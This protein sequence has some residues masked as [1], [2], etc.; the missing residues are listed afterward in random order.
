MLR[1][2]DFPW[3]SLA[4][5]KERANAFSD[6]SLGDAG[7]GLV[8]LSVGTP[9]Y[10]T[11]QVVREGSVVLIDTGCMYHGYSSDISRTWVQGEP[12]GRQREVWETVK[13][14]QE[15][16]LETAKIGAPVG[17]VDL[18]VR[19][20]YEGLGWAK[21]YG[22][23]GTSHRAGHGDTASYRQRSAQYERE[24]QPGESHTETCRRFLT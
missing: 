6:P 22:L 3:D 20:H 16:V 8:D 18:A 12:T 15:I 10:P 23:P 1:L 21:N 9:V 14:G 13:R 19:N 11:P 24:S 4:P 5:T 17:D 7:A 2:P